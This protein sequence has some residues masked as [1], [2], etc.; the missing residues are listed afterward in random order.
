MRTPAEIIAIEAIATILKTRTNGI[1]ALVFKGDDQPHL[2]IVDDSI[3]PPPSVLI[4]DLSGL[5]RTLAVT[6]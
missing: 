3:D 6:L 1:L 2:E 5:A 4:D